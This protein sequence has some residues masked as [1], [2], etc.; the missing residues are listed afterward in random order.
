MRCGWET[1]RVHADIERHV[2]TKHL[3]GPR[4]ERVD[5]T[6]SCPEHGCSRIGDRENRAAFVRHLIRKHGAEREVAEACTPGPRERN[7]RDKTVRQAKATV[8][9]FVNSLITTKVLQGPTAATSATP[10]AKH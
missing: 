10:G 9:T 1:K 3:D 7:H 8:R 4:R 5:L 6:L 2:R